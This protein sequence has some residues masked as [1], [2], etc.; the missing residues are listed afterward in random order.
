[1][2][3]YLIRLVALLTLSTM[4][5]GAK[6]VQKRDP[7]LSE[8][9][10]SGDLL[11]LVICECNLQNT[12]ITKARV[13]FASSDKEKA[14]S[15][16]KRRAAIFLKHLDPELRSAKEMKGLKYIYLTHANEEGTTRH[17]R[18]FSVIEGRVSY[19]DVK[20][21]YLDLIAFLKE[22]RKLQ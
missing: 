12:R 1:M 5:A 13:I 6:G 14:A 10:I 11:T 17:S 19:K 16:A 8:L 4:L 9:S 3:D 2:V 20:L 22:A 21:P 7:I 18:L 15:S